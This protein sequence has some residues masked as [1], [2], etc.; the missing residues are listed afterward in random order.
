MSQNYFYFE[1]WLIG[2]GSLKR[3]SL[4]YPGGGKAS[5]KTCDTDVLRRGILK[6]RVDITP[7]TLRD[8]TIESIDFCALARCFITAKLFTSPC[9]IVCIVERES[10][11]ITFSP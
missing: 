3:T 9:S 6:S 7:V 1:N 8:G 10:F 11:S 5:H 2:I 4:M